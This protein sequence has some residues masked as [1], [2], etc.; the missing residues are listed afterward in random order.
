MAIRSR[1]ELARLGTSYS[2][3]LGATV[4]GFVDRRIGRKEVKGLFPELT[5][6]LGQDITDESSPTRWTRFF[7]FPGVGQTLMECLQ[8]QRQHHIDLDNK[9]RDIEGA[10]RTNVVESGALTAPVGN[11]TRDFENNPADATRPYKIQRAVLRI[12]EELRYTAMKARAVWMLKQ[13]AAT[14]HFGNTDMERELAIHVARKPRGS[15]AFFLASSFR[16]ELRYE[17]SDFQLTRRE[18]QEAISA[19]FGFPS[20]TTQE[21]LLSPLQPDLHLR[22]DQPTV[23]RSNSHSTISEE[24]WFMLPEYSTRTNCR[25]NYWSEYVHVALTHPSNNGRDTLRH[26]KVRAAVCELLTDSGVRHGC[27]DQG[28]FSVEQDDQRF[29]AWKPDLTA[30]LPEYQ[31]IDAPGV[32]NNIRLLPTMERYIFDFK[33]LNGPDIVPYKACTAENQT[34]GVEVKARSVA[35]DLAAIFKSSELRERYPQISDASCSALEQLRLQ[36]TVHYFVVGYFCELNKSATT[37]LKHLAHVLAAKHWSDW[38]FSNATTAAAFKFSQIREYVQAAARKAHASNMEYAIMRDIPA[39]SRVQFADSLRQEMFEQDE[40]RHRMNMEREEAYERRSA[41][42]PAHYAE[43][44]PTRRRRR[45]APPQPPAQKH[46]RTQTSQRTHR[47]QPPSHAQHNPAQLS[48]SQQD[49]AMFDRAFFE[50]QEEAEQSQTSPRPRIQ[51]ANYRRIAQ[52]LIRSSIASGSR[53][54]AEFRRRAT[55]S[56][57]GTGSSVQGNKGSSLGRLGPGSGP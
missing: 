5:E 4:P 16:D 21:L 35:S 13:T 18:D 37:F 23:W 25:R 22:I 54:G 14:E 30:F 33:M 11:W 34:S 52:N 7:T 27:E 50:H 41:Y 44:G 51:P 43:W 46:A 38:G 55:G 17:G 39:E 24:D 32:K 12:L 57:M 3:T 40:Q 49:A 8:G 29:C 15:T 53:V 10:N 45:V 56:G 20:P 36:T 1:E 42:S 26:D 28:H 31:V 48:Q 47:T 2:N 9:R 19:H 6:Y